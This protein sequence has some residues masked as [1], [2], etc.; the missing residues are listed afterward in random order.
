[1]STPEDIRA[2]RRDKYG[3]AETDMSEDLERLAAG[4]PLAYVIGWVPFLGLKIHLESRPLIPRPETEWW[5]EKLIAHLKEKFGDKPFTVLDLCAGSGAIGLAIL[6]HIPAARVTFAELMP[7]H[8]QLIRRNIRQNDL[9]VS[10]T[11]VLEGDLFSPIPTGSR[12][13]IIVSNPPY[14][15]ENRELP[16]SV[17]IF[18]PPEAL[19]SG[20]DGLSLIRRIA[21][22]APTYLHAD[23]ELWVECDSEHADAA[24]DLLVKHVDKT[25]IRKDQYGRARLL[26]SYWQ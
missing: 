11:A 16:E 1:M 4:E 22:E 2:L 21:E 6:A 25:E 3:D 26:V 14:I 18:E 8:V 10:R 7:A 24:R 15:P 9:D 17:T 23:G 12:F 13:D 5:T 19:F 20:T